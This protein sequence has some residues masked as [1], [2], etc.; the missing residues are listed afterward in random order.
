MSTT[1]LAYEM[2]A[3]MVDVPECGALSNES[4]RF[5]QKYIH[6]ESGILLDDDKHYLIE[7]R[8]MPIV[9]KEDLVSLEALCKRLALKNSLSLATQ[10]IEAM[11]T[12][13]TLFFRDGALFDALKTLLLPAKLEEVRG[14]RKLRIWS[15]AASTGQ[16]AYSLAMLLLEAGVSSNEVEILGTDLSEQ[17]LTRARTGRYVQFEVNRGL[18]V[19]LLMRYFVKAGLEWQI[20]DEVRKMVR[21][22]QFDLRGNL[23]LLGTWDLVLCRNV[24]IYFDTHTKKEI[25]SAMRRALA[26]R[27]ALVLGC[28]ETVINLDD[29]FERK[30]IGLSTFYSVR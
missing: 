13:E 20:K 23:T 24:L 28:A 3:P 19:S 30:A 29:A 22:Q 5:L 16:E 7:S 9:R 11:T 18:P 10:V 21:F 2:P 27:G 15:A 25:L 6:D 26:P 1:R 12:N 4:Y 17:V 8:L 14:R